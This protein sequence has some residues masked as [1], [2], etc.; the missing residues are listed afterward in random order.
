VHTGAEAP[1]SFVLA[2]EAR[3][4]EAGRLG[5]LLDLACGRG[6]HARLAAGWGLDVV[7]LDRDAAALHELAAHGRRLGLPLA[8][9][10]ADAEATSGL[11]L[12]RA[13]FGAVLVTRFLYRPLAPTLAALLRPG[14]LLVYETFT[15]R[16]RELGQGPTNPSFLLEEE[17]LL[18]LFPALE[19]LDYAE[20]RRDRAWLAGLVARR[21]P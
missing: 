2:Q 14:G 17:E 7:G 15:S 9:L 12:R 8:L 11:P 10:R 4:R 6:R 5:P 16:Q 19:V 21:R 3:L 18:R 13:C 20:G 1:S